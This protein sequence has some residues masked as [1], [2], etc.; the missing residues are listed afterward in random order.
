MQKEIKQPTTDIQRTLDDILS[1]KP[2]YVT[3]RGKRKKIGWLRKDTIRRF[4]HI[5]LN[6][7]N[8]NK[9]NAKLCA[10]ILTNGAFVWFKPLLYKLRWRWYYYVKNLDDVEILSVV[11]AGKKKLPT[12]ASLLI[13]ILATG[14]VD[15]GMMMRKTEQAQATQA[16][17]SGEEPTH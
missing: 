3:I 10:A 13:T 1:E 16:E 4:T 14:M 5:A 9:R 17:Q 11:S 8:E 15:T 2:S 7:D 12:K 6:E